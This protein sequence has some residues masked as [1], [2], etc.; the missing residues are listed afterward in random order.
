ML[1]KFAGTAQKLI[2]CILPK[3]CGLPLA[4]YLV[5]QRGLTAVDLHYARGIGR[6]TPMRHRGVGETGEREIIR[7]AVPA[8]EAESYFEEIYR[9]AEINRP[10]GGIMFMQQLS[11]ATPF[12]LPSDLPEQD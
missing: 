7:I 3:G 6:I 2:T 9:V 4:R 1:E 10:H 5:H 8:A 12:V 11:A